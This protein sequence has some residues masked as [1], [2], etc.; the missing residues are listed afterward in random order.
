MVSK[1]RII[2]KQTVE[3]A[4]Q[5]LGSAALMGAADSADTEAAAREA[6]AVA[7]PVV[8]EQVFTLV[9]YPSELVGQ[10][11]T[12]RGLLMKLSC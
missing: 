8:E 11:G 9:C 2:C 6:T 1:L 10:V 4:E 12:G 7:A 5:A 3:P